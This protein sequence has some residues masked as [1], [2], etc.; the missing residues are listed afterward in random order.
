M[1]TVLI[2]PE[3]IERDYDE[4]GSPQRFPRTTNIVK[5]L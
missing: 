3:D 5:I 1:R 4:N 2:N